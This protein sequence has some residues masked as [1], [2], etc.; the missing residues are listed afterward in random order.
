[1]SVSKQGAEITNRFFLAIDMLKS[2]KRI[3]SLRQITTMYNLNYGNTHMMK[4]NPET[5]ILKP[6]LIANLSKDFGISVEWIIF[7][8]GNMFK[9]YKNC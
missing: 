3:K 5:Y 1:M 8:I 2:Q 4:S 7:G 6:E 9:T